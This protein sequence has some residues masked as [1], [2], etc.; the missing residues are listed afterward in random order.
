MQLTQ[1]D[2]FLFAV[3]KYKR[4]ELQQFIRDRQCFDKVLTRN[5]FV[6][7]SEQELVPQVSTKIIRHENLTRE[8]TQPQVS[9]ECTTADTGM[10]K[11]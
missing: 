4:H 9:I 7:E 10:Q 3:R 6:G 8:P 2:K 11:Q 5:N 1:W